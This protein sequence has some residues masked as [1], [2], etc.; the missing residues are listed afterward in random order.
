MMG[1]NICNA[2][3]STKEREYFLMVNID[4]HENMKLQESAG[5]M[6]LQRKLLTMKVLPK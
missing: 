1:K 3:F 5:I 4:F 6:L 2:V